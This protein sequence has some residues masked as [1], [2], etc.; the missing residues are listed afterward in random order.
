MKFIDILIMDESIS[1]EEAIKQSAASLENN[2]L[3]TKEYTEAIVENVKTNGNYIVVMPE[4][5]LPHSRPENGATGTGIV[6]TKANQAI[7][8]PDNTPVK[9]LF[10]FAANSAD[11]HVKMISDLGEILMDE[12]KIDALMQC[13]SIKELEDVLNDER[14]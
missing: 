7:D 3:C 14:S 1:W 12:D 11:E 4:I 5:A 2:G 10:T 9:L 13:T 8:F 6:L